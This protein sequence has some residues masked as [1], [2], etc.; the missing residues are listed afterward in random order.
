MKRF[1]VIGATLLLVAASCAIEEGKVP[2]GEGA[3]DVILAYAEEP[4][5]NDDTRL[6][7]SGTNLVWQKDDQITVVGTSA[8]TF[9]L[10]SGAGSSLGEFSGNISAA[11]AAPYFALSPADPSATVT[12]S[13]LSFTIPQEIVAIT[14]NIAG[15]SNP[16]VGEKNG[17]T[18]QFRNLF[19]FLKMSF[20]SNTSVKIKKIA[21]HDLGGNV[22]WGTCE[23][24][25]KKDG[26][27]DYG[28]IRMVAQADTQSN[29][30]D[31][32]FP[33]YV[34]FNSTERAYYFPVP[35]GALDYGFSIVLY[36]YDSAQ[37]DGIG[38]AY[39][40]LQK[41]SSPVTAQRSVIINMDEVMLT[42]KSEALEVKARGYYKSLFV[43]A[44]QNLSNYY[45]T[46]H[47]PWVPDMGLSNDY[48]YI[49][50]T[51]G[52]AL[53]EKQNEVLVYSEE[54]NNGVLLYPDGSPRFRMVYVNGGSSDE[55]GESL[56]QDGR[57]RFHDFFH[58]GGSYVGTCA[59]TFLATTWYTTNNGSSTY[60]RY[61][62]TNPSKNNSFGIWPGSIR[63]TCMPRSTSK[64]TNVYSAMKIL[65]KM[66]ELGLTNTNDTIELV[67]HHGG[68]Y[69]P[70]DSRNKD[71]E[72]DVLMSYQYTT[73]VQETGLTPDSTYLTKADYSYTEY[74][75]YNSY[76]FG[77]GN[78]SD[79]YGS[80]V[81][82]VAVWAYKKD[83]T[84][85]RAVLCGSHPE[86]EKS[87]KKLELMETMVKYALAGTGDPVVKGTL[88]IGEIT[89]MDGVAQGIGD[90]QYH[91]FKFMATSDLG[92]V[93]VKLR[94]SAGA[95]LYLALRKGDFAWLSDADY[96]LCNSGG[97]KTL[98][99]KN[100]QPGEWYL[101]VYCATTVTATK[102]SSPYYFS[103]SGNTA[104]LNGIPYSIGI[105]PSEIS[106]NSIDSFEG[107]N[108]GTVSLSMDD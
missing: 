27:L 59:G 1:I 21:L 4:S 10:S 9:T 77:F 84:S 35:P 91:H 57:D 40:F 19:G 106:A 12:S 92:T 86:A 20:T 28:H 98:L 72:K 79:G 15:N 50:G 89:S 52:T 80:K 2:S 23:V 101:S 53:T 49:A 5:A 94:S 107:D 30:I 8:T 58:A 41:I 63:H 16:M 87:G 96:V 6:Q 48:E 103:Y 66:K 90:R 34:T 42:E 67:R 93:K 56:T 82:E 51:N 45:T 100:L 102:Q 7:L 60:R 74:N 65:P 11:G 3:K 81:D 29:T 18:V 78:K 85:G 17:S 31:L 43:D 69:L 68:S 39:T 24:P 75:L 47:L 105:V 36:Q 104:V 108:V 64:Y 25:L 71:I 99:I 32:V 83:S 97:D 33:S 95:N 73:Q 88:K 26:T 46:S 76:M 61:G 54:D 14:G 62:N 55:H 13:K 22:L 44:G 70:N 38:K 37:P